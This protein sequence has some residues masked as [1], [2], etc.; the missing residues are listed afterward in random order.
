MA[1]VA[2]RNSQRFNTNIKAGHRFEHR[3]LEVKFGQSKFSKPRLWRG[4]TD[5]DF[6]LP[7]IKNNLP[8]FKFV[9]KSYGRFTEPPLSY[10]FERAVLTR[11]RN[12]VKQRR[13]K[14][15]GEYTAR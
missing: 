4:K 3:H 5:V 6:F 8:D 15:D 13:R 7:Q 1:G 2:R 11:I 12:Q 14:L 10:G 9:S